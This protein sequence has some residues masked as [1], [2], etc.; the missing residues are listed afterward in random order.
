MITNEKIISTENDKPEN[1]KTSC[2]Y[3][4]EEIFKTAKK[5]KHCGEILDAQMRDIENL[6]Q[7]RTHNVQFNNNVVQPPQQI[8]SHQIHKKNYPHFWHIVLTLI[9]GGFWLIFWIIFYLLRDKN[10]YN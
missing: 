7:Q 8:I 9:T 3:C 5:C 6:K 4:S 1:N 2:P 10:V